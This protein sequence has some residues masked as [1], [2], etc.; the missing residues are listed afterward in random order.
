MTNHG[1]IPLASYEPFV[2]SRRG[3]FE[4]LT[5]RGYGWWFAAFAGQRAVASLGVFGRDGLGRYQSVVTHPEHR[6]RGL[7]RRLVA[8]AGRYALTR[9]ERLVIVAE[10]DSTPGRVYRAC[11]FRRVSQ[12]F[13]LLRPPV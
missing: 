2:R 6:R 9:F 4:A 7:A 11:G 10:P 3:R 12:H 1:D 8:E 13:E 5:R